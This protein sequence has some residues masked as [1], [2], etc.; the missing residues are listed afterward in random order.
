MLRGKSGSA[1]AESAPIPPVGGRVSRASES[2]VINPLRSVDASVGA[3]VPCP[4][5]KANISEALNPPERFYSNLTGP[6]IRSNFS[7]KTRETSVFTS[8]SS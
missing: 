1:L 5:S 4:F 2:S 8:T 7:L 3:P 6:F